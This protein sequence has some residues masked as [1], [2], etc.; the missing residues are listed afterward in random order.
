MLFRCPL[1]H[2]LL[3]PRV[4]ESVPRPLSDPSLQII[5]FGGGGRGG[6]H[7]S[8]PF[9]CAEAVQLVLSSFSGGTAL[10]VDIDFICLLEE[11]SSE[12]SYVIILPS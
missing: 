10:S 1:N 12:S 5:L 9:L 6:S 4:C 3:C 8:Y 7:L 2:V 11:M